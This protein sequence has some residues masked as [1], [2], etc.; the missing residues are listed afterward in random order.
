VTTALELEAGT[1]PVGAAYERAAREGRALH[2]GFAAAW[3]FARVAETI[4]MEPTGEISF[5]Q[6]A[7]RR[8]GWQYS[9]A[10]PEMTARIVARV[11]RGLGDGALGIGIL[12]GYAPGY[13]RQEAFAIAR[14]AAQYGVPT[15]THTRSNSM[16]EPLSAFEAMEEIVALAA[17]TGAHM[18]VVHMNSSSGRDVP[19]IAELLAGAQARGLRITTE[20]YP[21]GAGS[22]V[23]GA[24]LFRG[25]WRA[26]TGMTAGDIER[27]GVPYTDSTLAEAQAREPG[28]WIVSHFLRP[29]RSPAD[30]ALLDRAVLFPGGA[31]ASDAMPWALDGVP[32]RGDVWPLP[33]KA[34]AHPRSAGTFTRFLR[35]YVRER[36]ATTLRE[37]LARMTIVPARILEQ[38]VPQMQRKGRVQVGADAD[39]VAFD[40]ATVSDMATYTAPNAAARGMRHVIVGGTPLIRDGVLDTAV[41]PGR[42]IRREVAA[43]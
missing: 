37:A 20:A 6:D 29:E 33:E 32:V 5:F 35:I 7:Q 25:E 9:V 28:T 30:Q 18:H 8:T 15:Y 11:E 10:S 14:L 41:R 17:G 40:L 34:F 3:A 4:G 22:T 42:A 13:G 43:R 31:I 21:Y 19:R 36:R 38:S 24:E 23:V 26:R 27:N 39:L 16:I 1:L 12:A 2:Y